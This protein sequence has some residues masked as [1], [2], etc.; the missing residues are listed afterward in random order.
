MQVVVP[1]SG[2]SSENEGQAHPSGVAQRRSG[3]FF[4]CG[5]LQNDIRKPK[6]LGFLGDANDDGCCLAVLF[7]FRSDVVFQPGIMYWLRIMP[8]QQADIPAGN[9]LHSVWWKGIKLTTLENGAFGHGFG[10]SLDSRSVFAQFSEWP[11][12][13]NFTNPGAYCTGAIDGERSLSCSR[14]QTHYG[15]SYGALDFRASN[16]R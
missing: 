9:V 6:L 4:L 15:C 3:H 2:F 12:P 16:S 1:I 7:S 5:S 14:F 10:S 13:F 8:C 11:R